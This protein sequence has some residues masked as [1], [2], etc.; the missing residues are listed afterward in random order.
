MNAEVQLSPT[1]P[2]VGFIRC[3]PPSTSLLR[4]HSQRPRPPS[5]QRCQTPGH[6]PSTRFLT[7]LTG[8][9][10][11]EIAG[12]LRPAAN[13]GFVSFRA[14]L[15]PAP[16]TRKQLARVADGVPRD[17]VHTL[18]RLPSP[19]A[20]PHHCGRCLLVVTIALDSQHPTEI[21]T[22]T[23]STPSSLGHPGPRTHTLRRAPGFESSDK[24][25]VR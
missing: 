4:V 3:S 9:S 7:A 11:H 20:V 25:L 16:A 13:L 17:A 21:G 24:T 8:C 2:L 5:A 12:L 23:C 19:T 15:W 10:T 1:S 14:R 6:V 22:S 18:R